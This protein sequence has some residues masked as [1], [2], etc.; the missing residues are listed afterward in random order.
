[1][2]KWTWKHCMVCVPIPTT[3]YIHEGGMETPI[4]EEGGEPSYRTLTEWQR[5][6]NFQERREEGMRG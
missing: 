6:G 1:M 5:D 2:G 4:K 3:A